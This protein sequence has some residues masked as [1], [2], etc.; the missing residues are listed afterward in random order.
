MRHPPVTSVH[1]GLMLRRI[2]D[3]GVGL[4]MWWAPVISHTEQP[5]RRPGAW[6][7]GEELH[8]RTRDEVLHTAA[9]FSILV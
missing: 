2:A 9:V 6:W 1:Y 7:L 5:K 8:I 3:G 4:W